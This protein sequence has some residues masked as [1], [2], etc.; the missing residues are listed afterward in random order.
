MFTMKYGLLTTTS[1]NIGDE[2]QS[3]AAYRFL[4][5][6]DYLIH[7][8]RIDECNFD[9]SQIALIMNHWWLWSGKHFPPSK[10]IVPLYVSFHLQYRLRNEKF[11]TN[12]VIEHF[13][14]HEPIGCRDVGTAEFLS[15]HGINAYFSGCLT[16]TLLPNPALK[17]KFYSDYILCVDAPEEVVDAIRKR[18]GREVL[19]IERHQ[20]A[21]FSFQ[22]R[23]RMAKFTLFLYHNAHCVVTIALHAALPSTAFGTPVCVISQDGI[24]AKTRF[25]GLEGCFNIVTKEQFIADPQSYDINTPPRNPDTYRELAQRIAATCE[26]FTGYDSKE[27]ILEDNYNP[28]RDIAKIMPYRWESVRKALYFVKEKDLLK[29]YLKRKVRGDDRFGIEP[30]R[31]CDAW[32]VIRRM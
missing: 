6:V 14:K 17:N 20:K 11:M 26:D 31:V 22:E 21:C 24:D 8:E 19:C 28:I 23:L 5:R 4:P 29:V 18:T 3:L 13:K 25:E 16:T 15:A 9:E 32:G 12:S 2:I 10:C 27:P 7:R 30:S 1:M